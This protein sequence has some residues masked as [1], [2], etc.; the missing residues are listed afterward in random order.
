MTSMQIA[1]ENILNFFVNY[2]VEKFIIFLYYLNSLS[3]I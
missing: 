2:A 1:V 3:L